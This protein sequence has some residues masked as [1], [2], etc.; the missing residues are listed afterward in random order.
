MPNT[1]LPIRNTVVQDILDKMPAWPILWGN[2]IVFV[3]LL[4]LMSLSWFIKYPDALSAELVVE[5]KVPPCIINARC[6]GLIDTVL[7]TDGQ[8][9]KINDVL[10]VL[11]QDADYKSLLQLD[12]L[13][14]ALY[15][16]NLSLVSF[17]GISATQLGDIAPL[18]VLLKRDLTALKLNGSRSNYSNF[19]AT[20]QQLKMTLQQW[21]SN[22]ILRASTNG[23][24]SSYTVAPGTFIAAG[25]PVFEIKSSKPNPLQYQVKILPA[26]INKLCEGQEVLF[27]TDGGK[28]HLL[29]QLG[30][31]TNCK[32]KNGYYR[33]DLKL[34]PE[35]L[36]KSE[37][38][39][40]TGVAT[41]ILHEHRLCERMFANIFKMFN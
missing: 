1:N 5:P 21:D 22:Y 25:D 15:F 26:D 20:W 4:S 28:Q 31:C 34:E 27:N 7:V 23:L 32:Q 10:C 19:V 11:R 13:V 36:V 38:K 9:V 18:F 39:Q 14:N 12:S 40:I 30:I 6:N 37:A 35:D 41:I 16:E 3:L 24:M 2:T 17:E 29:A 8:T 33:V